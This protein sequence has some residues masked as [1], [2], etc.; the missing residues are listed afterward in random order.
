MRIIVLRKIL[1]LLLVLNNCFIGSAGELENILYISDSEYISSNGLSKALGN[2]FH[3]TYSRSIKCSSKVLPDIIL[4]SCGHEI[5]HTPKW[6][7]YKDVYRDSCAVWMKEIKEL[8]PKA[9]VW[10]CNMPPVQ[11]TYPLFASTYS[12]WLPEINCYLKR[13]VESNGFSL[14]DLYH[15]LLDYPSFYK[16]DFSLSEEGQD[17]IC[18]RISQYLSGKFGG[19]SMAQIYGDGMVL[20]A[21]EDLTISGKADMGERI[22]VCIGRQKRFAITNELGD[23]SVVFSPFQAS[24][25]NYVM[26]ISSPNRKLIFKNVQMGEV[27]VC[28]GQ[29]NMAFTVN[30]SLEKNKAFE[31]SLDC[32]IRLYNME[33]SE[34]PNDEPWTSEMLDRCN[35]LKY[36]QDSIQWEPAT[37]ENIK[38][39]SAVAWFFGRKLSK[40]LGKVPIGLICNA[41][42]GSPAEAWASRELVEL[43]PYLIQPLRIGKTKEHYQPW[44]NSRIE[45]N[46][47]YAG[48]AN[49][50]HYFSPFYLFSSGMKPLSSYEVKGIIWYQGESNT[51]NSDYYFHLMPILVQGFRDLWNMDLPFFFAQLSSVD[52]VSWP[53]FRD[54]QRRLLEVIPNSGMAV[55]SDVGDSLDVHPKQKKIVGDRLA[56][57]ALNKVYKFHVPFSGPLFRSASF[58]GNHVIISFSYAE[59]GLCSSDSSSIKGM[60]VAGRDGIFFP[61]KVLIQGENLKV[62][63][64]KVENIYSVRYAWKPFSTANLVNKVGFPASTFSVCNDEVVGS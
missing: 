29:S 23:W 36:Y 12:T 60:E 42:S 48:N 10:V 18:Q 27:W 57:W 45:H 54:L 30:Q 44:V 2:S 5:L 51:H 15:L 9:K 6:G 14:I 39:F 41:I 33:R 17:W 56:F 7:E 24:L 55:T 26:T 35:N 28:S 53:M 8:Y 11:Y 21:G 1:L 47:L 31:D 37:K 34:Q 22:E 46:I 50:S 32:H 62:W 40:Y 20:Q 19:L 49:Q 16:D 4:F 58:K 64:E 13:I 3:V 52:R 63:S 43:N 61:A 59:G 25:K 38:R